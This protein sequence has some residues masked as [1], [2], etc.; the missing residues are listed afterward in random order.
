M[1]FLRLQET[2]VHGCLG[3]GIIGVCEICR[4]GFLGG[5]SR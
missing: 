3:I 1:T 4:E 2:V 5:L